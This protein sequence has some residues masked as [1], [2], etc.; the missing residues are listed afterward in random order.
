MSV[1]RVTRTVSH[2]DHHTATVAAREAVR[3]IVDRDSAHTAVTEGHVLDLM[4]ARGFEREQTR[5][6]LQALIVDDVIITVE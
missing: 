6:A 3:E 4:E 2:P 5:R 1:A